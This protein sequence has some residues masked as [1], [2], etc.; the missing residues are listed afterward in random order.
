MK[1]LAQEKRPDSSIVL[2]I[3]LEIATV[4]IERM[5]E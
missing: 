3:P 2:P 1:W 5:L 4:H